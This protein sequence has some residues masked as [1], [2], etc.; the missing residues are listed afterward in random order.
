MDEIFTLRF[1]SEDEINHWDTHVQQNRYNAGFLQTKAYARTKG[2][3]GWKIRYVVYEGKSQ[4]VYCYFLEK[5]VGLLGYLWY[6]PTGSLQLE[7]IGAAVS[8]NK[9]FVHLHKLPVFVIKIEP[10]IRTTP[11]LEEHTTRLG[12]HKAM[13]LQAHNSTI[14]IDLKPTLP[15]NLGP[16]A[17]RDIRLAVKQSIDVRRIPFSEDAS[18]NMYS[19]M[20]TVGRGKGSAFIR[21][22]DYYRTFWHNFSQN[23]QG[24]FYFA[25]ENDRP[26]VGAFIIT[27]GST[28][29]YK[30]GG[31][32]PDISHKKRYSMAVQWQALQDAKAHSITTYDLCGV[33]PKEKLNDP[34]HPYYGVG[35][36]KL[37]FNKETVDYCGCYDQI[38]RPFSYGLWGMSERI[39]YKFYSW[40]HHDLFF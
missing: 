25:Y 18:R 10:S 39:I 15:E 19:L 26:V 6:M 33:P 32:T 17:R 35:Q 13:P 22:F 16:K 21:P 31:S 34:D 5:K 9:R 38:L 23:G 29:V 30:D 14:L 3:F 7:D 27:V 37:K 8:A 12:L 24:C 4:K 11:Q 20:K 40:K 36:F 1:A 28:G 2:A